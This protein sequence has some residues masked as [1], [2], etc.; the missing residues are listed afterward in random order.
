LS[1]DFKLVSSFKPTGDQPAAI[2]Q[3]G[4]GLRAGEKFQTLLGVTGSGKTFSLACMLED[5]P[6]PTL[7]ISHNKTLAAQLYAEFSEFFPENAVEY[8]VSY[9]DYFQ[10]EAYVPRLD[11]YVEKE[12]SINEKLEQ[13]RM[14]TIH[15]LLER[16]DVIVVASVSCIFGAGKPEFYRSM[17]IDLNKKHTIDRD[18]VLKSLVQLQYERNDLDTS[19]G[20][21]RARGQSVDVFPSYETYGVRLEFFGDEIERIHEF[22]PLTGQLRK[23][24]E[25]FRIYP[26]TNFTMPPELMEKATA[27][28]EEEL[29][30]QL[31]KFRG[32]GKLLE[33][34]RLEQRARFDLEMLREMGSCPGI[35]NYSRHF[36]GRKPGETPWTLVDYF[37]EDFLI[38]IDESH[39][40]LPQ[41]RA[42]Y[43]GNL[44][45][46]ETLIDYG[47]RLPSALDNR[48]MNFKEFLAK[49]NQVVFV[50]ATPSDYEREKSKRIVEQIVRP[51]GLI[52]P[53]I[54]IHKVEG[55]IDH[56]LEEIR[57]RAARKE[58]ILVTTLTKKMAENL[59]DYL[60]SM[61]VQTRYLH[62]EIDTLD[63][64]EILRDLRLGEFNTLV[65]INLL[66]E[67]LDLPE[68]SLVA[69][70]DA[71]K[72]GFL[73]SETSLIQTMG[74]ASRNINGRVILY[75]DN[76]TNSM[77]RAID[78]TQRRRAIQEEYNKKHGITPRSIEKPIR[79]AI[80]AQEGEEP[81]IKWAADLDEREDMIPISEIPHYIEELELKMLEA[82]KQ[83]QF[84][85]AAEYRDKITELKSL[86]QE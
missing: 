45:R 36:D 7:V 83:L 65:G 10:P 48:P 74:R 52:D 64:I 80:K 85:R 15:S 6:R 30:Q 55:Q 16:R 50:S 17:R 1:D 23:E 71:D 82:A 56:L 60:A 61:N 72:E 59:A 39:A 44:S 28:I 54:I 35:E 38:I 5:N 37:P 77:Q 46:K 2:K 27:N 63:R 42:M 67:G 14:S 78:E 18:D 62:S 69:I 58:R 41:L 70:L 66:R 43:R 49:T 25:S 4:E 24:L 40:T 51:T 47:F 32:R 31:R 21:F 26:A 53:E 75:A 86:L 13:M 57:T 9:Y 33:A 81:L 20:T 76:I 8:F 79:Y 68:V 19:P 11:L 12:T 34:Q 73:R 22:D 3:L 29:D 84:E